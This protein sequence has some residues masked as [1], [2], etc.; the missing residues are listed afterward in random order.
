MDFRSTTVADLAAQIGARRLSAR[1]V[2]AAALDRIDRFDGEL[3]AFVAVDPD[4]ALAE[5][6]PSTSASRPAPTSAPSPASR[7]R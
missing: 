1:E 7:S 2:T 4:S 6:R 5:A 3:G